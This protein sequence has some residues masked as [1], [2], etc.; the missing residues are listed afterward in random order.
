MNQADLYQSELESTIRDGRAIL[1]AGTGV[2]IAASVDESTKPHP[3]ASWTG[4]LEGGLE[5]LKE[6][7]LM[8]AEDADAHLRLLRKNPQ[9]HR[10]ISAAEDIMAGMGGDQ[11]EH[12]KEWLSRTVGTIEGHDRSVLD[13]LDAIRQHGHLLATTNYDALLLGNPPTLDAITWQETDALIG[14]VRKWETD[15]IIFLHG[16]WRKPESV[17]LDW[18]S[19]DRIARDEGYREDLAAFWKTN[20]WVYVGCG[21]AG[22]TDPD[23]GLL[24]ERYSER[25]RRAGQWDYCLVCGQDQRQE[26]QA[27]FDTLKL[28]IRAVSYGEKHSD[29]APYLHSLLPTPVV[30]TAE[31]SVVI[32]PTDAP[33]TIPQPPAFY[34]EPDYIGSHQF[35]GRKRELEDLSDWA[36]PADPTNLLLYEAIGGNGKSMLT[37]EWATNHAEQLRTGDDAWAGRF[38]YSLL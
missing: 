27:H 25:A 36:R 22:L 28:N 2:S 29:L 26:F 24:L 30:E 16:Y 10:F 38:W 19:Y 7:K 35:V 6:H 33:A 11:S 14:A 15:R 13:A 5:W 8:D 4:L 34:A 9:T 17:I 1:V 12:F 20:T 31:A 23:F 18:K 3:Q 32:P 21:V 37:W